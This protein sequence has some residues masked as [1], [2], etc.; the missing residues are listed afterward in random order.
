MADYVLEGPKWLSSTISWSF[1]QANVTGQTAPFSSYFAPGP[2]EDAIQAA[3]AEW[4]SET[5]LR[6]VQIPDSSIAD[7]RLGLDTFDG[8][9]GELGQTSY[10]YAVSASNLQTFLNDVVV[11]FDSGER[12]SLVNGQEQIPDSITFE[13]IALHEIGHALGLGHYTA[14]PAIMNP[15]A[16]PTITAL[17]NPTSTASRP[18]TVPPR[19]G[20]AWPKDPSSTVGRATRT[21]SSPAR[22][23]TR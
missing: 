22:P 8:P 2:F 4:G 5:G 21:I 20:R 10:V 13:S 3:F 17:T 7:I 18:S 11:R 6:F 14:G 16:S 1:A 12:Y 9:S 15:E 23:P 19:P